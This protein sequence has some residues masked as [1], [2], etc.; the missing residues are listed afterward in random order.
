MPMNIQKKIRI[1]Q[2]RVPEYRVAL[3]DGLARLYGDAIEIVAGPETRG[4]KSVPLSTMRYDYNHKYCYIGPFVWQCGLSLDGLTRGDVIVICG[5]ARE[6]SSMLI[7]YRARRRGIKVIWWGHHKTSTSKGYR[8]RIRLWLAKHLS[9]VV[10][11]YTQTGVRYFVEHGF[12]ARFVLATG[13]TI[14]QAPIKKAISL[15]NG[16]DPYQ[17][18]DGV[19]F[20]SRLQP[21]VRLDLLIRAMCDVRLK[22]VELVV[23][24]DG[25]MKKEY[26]ELA[27]RCGVDKRIRW[28][29]AV[30]D[31]NVLAPWFLK[32]KVFVYPGAVG[33]SILHAM[34]YGLPVVVHGN[35][36]HQMP[37]YEIMEDGKTGLCFEENNYLDLADKITML[38]RNE[39]LR[40]QMGKY[41]KEVAYDKYSMEQ[42]IKNYS[43]AIE[44]CLAAQD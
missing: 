43:R 9:D 4:G 38:V 11:T 7:A 3:L 22:E 36:A 8:I 24:G 44:C 41:C 18:R 12:D 40:I 20:C 30:G 14:D 37:E 35:A 6:L 2:P 31:Q 28:L 13:N 42:M 21:K 5:D 25:P 17:G 23:I 26:L 33:L 27:K 19:L 10:L 16:N 32:A 29:G 34:S 1:F 39:Q 15:F